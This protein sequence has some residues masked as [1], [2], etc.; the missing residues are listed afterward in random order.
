MKPENTAWQALLGKIAAFF[1]PKARELP[2][3]AL[4]EEKNSLGM[5][6]HGI[7][8]E[9]KRLL[10]RELLLLLLCSFVLLFFEYGGVV[11]G[12][13]YPPIAMS[14][15]LLYDGV[16]ILLFFLIVIFNRGLD[17][18]IP[19]PEDLLPTMTAEEKE[20]YIERFRIGKRRARTLL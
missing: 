13:L 3:P 5:K 12:R 7:P 8:K 17:T 14:V 4:P 18:E 16:S 20:R 15:W 1:L 6:S 19:S 10:V 2:P 11:F 9:K